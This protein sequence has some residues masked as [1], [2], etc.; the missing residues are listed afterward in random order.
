[1]ILD[2]LENAHLYSALNKGFQAAFQFL[3]RSDLKE[4]PVDT[5]TIDDDRVYAI[6]AKDPVRKVVA[7]VIMDQ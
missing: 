5:Y 2:V 6:I 1:M 3:L 4:L 7:K